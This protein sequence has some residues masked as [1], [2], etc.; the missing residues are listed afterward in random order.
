MTYATG[1]YKWEL[2]IST[3]TWAELGV[4]ERAPRDSL[5][6]AGEIIRGDATGNIPLAQINQGAEYSLSMV[7]KQ[8][9]TVAVARLQWPLSV[10]QGVI[11]AAKLGCLQDTHS[12]RMTS[13]GCAFPYRRH[14]H[15]CVVPDGFDIT[16]LWGNTLRNVPLTL[17]CFGVPFTTGEAPNQVTNYRF[18]TQTDTAPT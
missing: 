18:F 8:A 12:I 14:F 9:T 6:V 10:T 15:S 3:D 17:I 5:R 13:L 7:F 2:E 4:V 1:P 16:Q 11:D